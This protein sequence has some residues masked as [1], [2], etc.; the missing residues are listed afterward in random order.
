MTIINGN[1]QYRPFSLTLFH[2]NRRM[3]KELEIIPILSIPGVVFF[4]NT[5]LPLFVAEPLYIQ[6]IHDCIENGTALG[7]AMAENDIYY[8]SGKLKPKNI[9]GLGRPIILEELDDGSLKVLIRGIG[10]GKIIAEHQHLPY[11][12]YLIERH[13]DKSDGLKIHGPRI[14]RLRA[15]LD[16]WLVDNI[17]E[18]IEREAFL[19]TLTSIYHVVDYIG[20]FLIQDKELRQ[21]LLENESINERIYM[22]NILLKEENPFT[23]DKGVLSAIKSFE[24]LEKHAKIGH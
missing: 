15:I 19:R 23:E 11:P 24:S 2:Y 10:R 5:S 6:L 21:L 14:T 13:Y 8:S 3:A 18:P 4:P 22:L 1:R 9:F 20:M 12:T 17:S 7:I 16:E